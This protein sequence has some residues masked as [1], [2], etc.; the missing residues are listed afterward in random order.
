LEFQQQR[1]QALQQRVMQLARDARPLTDPSFQCLLFRALPLSEVD[2]EHHALLAGLVECGTGEQHRDA[3]A[4][5]AKQFLFEY[6]EASGCAQLGHGLIARS[7]P[8]RRRQISPPQPSQQYLLARKSEHVKG[9][10]VRL[11][12]TSVDSRDD[13]ADD[14]RLDQ[15]ADLPLAQLE[16]NTG[17][18][19]RATSPLAA[20]A[21]AARRCARA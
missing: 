8:F 21:P 11:A 14:V 19:S 18:C 12:D 1:L 2:H 17:G 4:V 7:L 9:G 13:D 5:L 20:R 3:A 10:L 6:V 15:P 16:F